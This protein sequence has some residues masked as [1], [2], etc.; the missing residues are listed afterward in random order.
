MAQKKNKK[1]PAA[2]K[3]A[4]V[5]KAAPGAKGSAP[6]ASGG[7]RKAAWNLRVAIFILLVCALVFA[8]S[9]LVF[10]VCMLPTLV[11]SIIDKNAHKTLWL[12]IGSVN[13]AGTV[14]AWFRLWDMGH[15]MGSALMVL[16]NPGVLLVAYGAAAAGWVIHMNVTPLVAALIIR[17]NEG[18]I[19]DIDKRQRELVRK[20]GEDIAKTIAGS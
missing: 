15:D 10:A 20:W 12:T 17:R 3:A 14:P 8:P 19:K 4:S 9:A 7:Q 11:A 16:S 13:L 6:E 5:G 2:K 18:R 1:A